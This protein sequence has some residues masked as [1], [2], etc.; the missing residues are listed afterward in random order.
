MLRALLLSLSLLLAGCAGY[1]GADLVAGVAREAD[2]R[3]AMGVP[4][5]QWTLPGGGRQLA[6]PRGPAG[7]ETFM[8]HLDA[9]G[10]L[11]RIENVLDMTHFARIQPDM[12]QEEVLQLLGPSQPQWTAYFKARDELVWEWRYCDSW[13]EAARFDVLFDA[14][15]K[16]VR[17]TMS[18][19]E[20]SKSNWRVGC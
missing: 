2:V 18:W 12:T 4:A 16:T 1:G 11:E 9:A 14:T 19:T 8:V 10:R 7:Y 13:R 20:S 15:K 5:M 17:S 6:Y 3:L